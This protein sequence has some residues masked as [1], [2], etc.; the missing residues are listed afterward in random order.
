MP[1]PQP[2][3]STTEQLAINCG[4]DYGGEEDDVSNFIPD[5]DE[6]DDEDKDGGVT[7]EEEGIPREIIKNEWSRD[8]DDIEND[9]DI[10]SGVNTIIPKQPQFA[11]Y[12]RY[13]KLGKEEVPLSDW[14]KNSEIEVLVGETKV[15]YASME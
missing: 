8:R 4:C 6:F 3:P 5:D 14:D 1:T 11:A 7:L 2:T 15:D 10:P 12:D 9:D 13:V